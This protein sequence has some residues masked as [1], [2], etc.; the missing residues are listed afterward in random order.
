MV[1]ELRCNSTVSY[2]V[3]E[4]ADLAA[5][6]CNQEEMK[7]SQRREQSESERVNT[8]WEG[9][10]EQK[11]LTEIS[12]L[13]FITVMFVKTVCVCVCVEPYPL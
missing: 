12:R 7:S 11:V 2:Q 1:R 3:T 5:I 6:L 8:R 9:R 4:L 10:E 13:S